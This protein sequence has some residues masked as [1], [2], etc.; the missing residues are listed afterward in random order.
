MQSLEFINK[1]IL[2]QSKKHIENKSYLSS[3]LILTIG[4][5][6]MGGFFDKKPLKSPKQS[7]LRFNVAIDKLLGGKYSLYN[8]NDFLYEALRNQFVHSLLIGNKFKVSLNEKHLSE[9]DGFIVFNPLTF[10]D[11]IENA[12]KKLVKLTSE[13]RIVL[14]KIPDNYLILTPFI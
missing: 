5:E 10:Y 8:K 9:K 6:I 11:D 13:N 7:K 14:K 2:Q 1:F 4:F 12:S 3:M